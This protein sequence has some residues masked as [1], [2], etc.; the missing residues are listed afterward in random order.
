MT[1]RLTIETLLA[2]CFFMRLV[3][4]PITANMGLWNQQSV[5]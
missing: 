4:W 2:A 5:D 1:P 3:L